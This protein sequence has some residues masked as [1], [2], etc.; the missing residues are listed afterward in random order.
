MA[1]HSGAREA[2]S[3]C[4]CAAVLLEKKQRQAN[5]H[6]KVNVFIEPSIE[7]E[8]IYIGEDAVCMSS[9]RFVSTFFGAGRPCLRR[10]LTFCFRLTAN[11]GD[12]LDRRD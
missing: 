3:G 9:T 2:P 10:D 4:I 8:D 5:A 6:S 11:R 12:G 1:S 7:Q